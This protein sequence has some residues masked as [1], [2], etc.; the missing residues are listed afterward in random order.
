MKKNAF[1][2]Y[3][4]ICVGT[5]VLALGMN[6]FLVPMKLSSGG[7]GTIGTVLYHTLNIPLSVTNLVINLILF[8]FGFKVLGR[9]SVAKTI[10]GTI[11][12]SLFLELCRFF[13]QPELDIIVSVA[14]G[15]F[16]VGLG[17][18]L[19][20]RVGGSTGG[21]D[22]LGLILKR[23]L[24]HVS[25]AAIIL[26][27]DLVIIAISGV[28]FGNFVICIYSAI[29]MFISSKVSDAIINIGRHAKSIYITSSKNEEIKAVILNKFKRGATEIY[30][31]GAFSNKKRLMLLCVLS[32]KEAPRLV[33]EVKAIDKSAF[34]VICD[35]REV[36]GEGFNENA[37]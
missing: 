9:G 12:L 31:Q 25:L 17:V 2:E 14:T 19:V 20:V 37:M 24:P 26:V 32:P 21:S 18:G 30:T 35:A 3:L 4:L 22:F 34:V 28:V 6:I 5:F 33:K 16:L 10:F 36:L 7:V 29:C 1:F 27:I 11:S 8:L 13:P 23:F 15:G